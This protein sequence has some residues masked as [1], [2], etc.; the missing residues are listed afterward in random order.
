MI[1]KGIS[2]YYD[3]IDRLERSLL[4]KPDSVLFFTDNSGEIF[5]D[6]PFIQF[7][8]NH[9][10]QATLVVKGGPTLN[11]LSRIEIEIRNKS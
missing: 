7:I 1:K 9:A 2:F 8:R 3:D 6:I 10:R 11:D 5:F 4:T